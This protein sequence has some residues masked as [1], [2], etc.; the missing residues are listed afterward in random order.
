[1]SPS[2]QRRLKSRSGD[3]AG[4]IEAWARDEKADGGIEVPAPA[5]VEPRKGAGFGELL[6]IEEGRRRLADY[7]TDVPL[8]DWAGPVAGST[9]LMLEM[10][11]ARSTLHDWQQRGEVIALLK[12]SRA[13]VFPRAQFVDGRPVQGVRDILDVAGSPRRAWF[14]MVH[15]SPL[16]GDKRPI[17]LLKQDRRQE[18]VKAVRTVFDRP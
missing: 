5:E 9:I 18:V 14:W 6:D 7:A 16:L 11:I 8:E 3:L 12:G 17:D 2:Q 15:P 13:H 4:I 1:L 10:K